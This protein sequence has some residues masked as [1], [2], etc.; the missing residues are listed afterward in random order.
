MACNI[1]NGIARGC[2]ENAGGLYQ[3]Y[4][5][6]RPENVEVGNSTDGVTHISSSS[7]AIDFYPFVP[8]KNSSDF[9]ENYQVSLENGTVGYEQVATMIFSKMEATKANQ[10]KMLAQGSLLVIVK[11]KNNNY[12]LMGENDGAEL[13]AGNAGSGKVLT[14]L[15]GYN[16]TLTSL[17]GEMAPQIIEANINI[18]GTTGELTVS[19]S[20]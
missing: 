18:D 16:I 7:V 13:S 19:V 4:I 10:I 9:T 3:L 17:E 6:S 2:R 14:D 8:N 20:A 11:D 12:F 1:T 15:N 5:A